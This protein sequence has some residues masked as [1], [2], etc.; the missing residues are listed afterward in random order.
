M[1][2]GVII[3]GFFVAISMTAGG[4]AWDNAKKYIEDVILAEKVLRLI[5]LKKQVILLVFHIKIPLVHIYN[6]MIKDYKYCGSFSIL[7]VI[8]G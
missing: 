2:L 1:L 3:T 5:R 8:A 4:G 6:P 7:A